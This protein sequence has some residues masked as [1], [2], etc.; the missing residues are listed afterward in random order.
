MGVR[1]CTATATLGLV[2]SRF[3]WCICAY[4]L[5]DNHL[6]L[7]VETQNANLARGMR[8][9]N[10]VYAQRCVHYSTVSRRLRCEEARLAAV[11]PQDLTPN[12]TPNR[13]PPCREQGKPASV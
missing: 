6:H 2:V 1:S 12:L 11:A 13:V 5:M 8:Q 10:G 4:F 9:L 7:L 3:D